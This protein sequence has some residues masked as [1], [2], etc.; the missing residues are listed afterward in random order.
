MKNT[1]LWIGI[2]RIG[3][4]LELKET[5]NGKKQVMFSIAVNEDY[6]DKDENEVKVVN[7]VP[8]VAYGMQAENLAKFKKKG[9]LIL[10]RGALTVRNG[11]DKDGND[12]T[13]YNIRVENTEWFGNKSDEQ[14]SANNF[15]SPGSEDYV[16]YAALDEDIF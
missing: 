6:K 15:V 9:D 16:P 5:S 13:Y 10:V 11:K 3:Q 8:C 14:S 12:R 4:D 7:W 1:N 2:G